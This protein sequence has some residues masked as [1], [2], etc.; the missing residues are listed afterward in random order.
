[1]TTA[2][3][4]SLNSFTKKV[5]T[6][7]GSMFVTVTF[8][9]DAPFE[10]FANIGKA[11]QCEKKWTEAIGRAISTGLRNG[12]PASAYIEQ[13]SNLTCVPVSDDGRMIHSP[14]DGISLVLKESLGNK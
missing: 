13:L 14:A 7:H 11:G 8:H 5:L 3:P 9:E 4:S 12:V 10:L 1:M 2:R 6:D